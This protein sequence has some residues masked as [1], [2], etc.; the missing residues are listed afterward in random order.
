MIK[1]YRLELS[2][3]PSPPLPQTIDEVQATEEH[4]ITAA[5]N[6]IDN[7]YSRD[8]E[9]Q[10]R[11]KRL[12]QRLQ[13]LPQLPA[14]TTSELHTFMQRCASHVVIHVNYSTTHHVAN[15]VHTQ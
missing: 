10:L 7:D 2:R 11:Q 15:R 14:M 5:Y 3:I 1:Y 12:R 6:D 8:D 9:E 4:I 13:L